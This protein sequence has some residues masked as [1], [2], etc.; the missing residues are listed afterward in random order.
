MVV[1]VHG[2][3]I[4]AASMWDFAMALASEGAV[5]YNVDVTMVEPYLETIGEEACAV[6]F[7]RATAAD[8]GGDPTRVTL[9]GL[10][11]GARTGAVVALAGD[12]YEDGC[13]VTEESGLPDAFVGYE[14]AY[15]HATQPIGPIDLTTLEETDPDVWRAIDPYAQIGGNPGVEIVLVHGDDVDR[16]W[17]DIP[18]ERSVA[19]HEALL[20]AGYDAELVVVDGA[21][22]T[23]VLSSGSEGFTA[24]VEQVM[25]TAAG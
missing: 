25:Q 20:E 8:Y 1:V 21:S 2:S 10:S 18:M 15:D 13:V 5:V 7:A 23:A 4:T 16:F 12:D 6:R 19:F 22:H 9:F 24:T 11:G 3:G 14:G 17:Y